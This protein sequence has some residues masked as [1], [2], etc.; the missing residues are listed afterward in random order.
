MSL[1]DLVQSREDASEVG[2]EM[3][4]AQ[5]LMDGRPRQSMIANIFLSEPDLV[6]EEWAL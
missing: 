2:H 1:S 4:L 3:L 6:S 5:A